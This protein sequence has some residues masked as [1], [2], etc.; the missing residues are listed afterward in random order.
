[1]ATM[2]SNGAKPRR[3]F[4]DEFNAGWWIWCSG[5]E[6]DRPGFTGSRLDRVGRAAW[7]HGRGLTEATARRKD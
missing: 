1:M 3:S 4:T 5:R 2:A 6:D 7:V